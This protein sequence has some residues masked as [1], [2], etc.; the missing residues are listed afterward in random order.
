MSVP[1]QPMWA[2]ASTEGTFLDLRDYARVVARRWKL[3]AA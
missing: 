3:I 1:Q 2:P